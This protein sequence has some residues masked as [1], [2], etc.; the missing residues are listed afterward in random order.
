MGHS[1]RDFGRL[2]AQQQAIM[3]EQEL[4]RHPGL[5]GLGNQDWRNMYGGQRV[6]FMTPKE[7]PH[8]GIGKVTVKPG[9]VRVGDY[10]RKENYTDR[11]FLENLKIWLFGKWGEEL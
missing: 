1:T 3:N 7:K 5:Y 11:A 4:Q 9:Y 8:G 6:D 10:V 2:C